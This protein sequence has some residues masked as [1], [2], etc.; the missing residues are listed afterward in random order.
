MISKKIMVNKDWKYLT[1]TTAEPVYC[2]GAIQLSLVGN[3]ASND[4][5]AFE[6]V[7]GF[8]DI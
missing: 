3:S 4:V 1:A 2:P 7:I 8:S 6:M 5:T